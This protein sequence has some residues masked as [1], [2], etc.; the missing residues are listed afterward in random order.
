MKKDIQEYYDG[1]RKATWDFV[2]PS[3]DLADNVMKSLE[4]MLMKLISFSN[5]SKSTV[6][7]SSSHTILVSISKCSKL[8]I[9]GFNIIKKFDKVGLAIVKD[10]NDVVTKLSDIIGQ[11]ADSVNDALSNLG[12]AY[13]NFMSKFIKSEGTGDRNKVVYEPVLKATDF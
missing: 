1:C 5:N 3:H 9:S 4:I 7:A 11:L 8:G 10:L 13:L 6:L 2:G 12:C